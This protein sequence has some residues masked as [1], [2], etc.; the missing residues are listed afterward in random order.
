MGSTTKGEAIDSVVVEAIPFGKCI[1]SILL[2]LR[3][4]P[5]QHV[6][7]VIDADLL[8][9]GFDD[10]CRLVEQVVSIQDGYADT[11]AVGR[12]GGT[13]WHGPFASTL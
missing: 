4:L 3:V 7:T 1:E 12:M 13:G 11:A 10:R 8:A 9:E 6:R 2:I 5:L